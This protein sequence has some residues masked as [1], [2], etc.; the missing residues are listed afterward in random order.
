MCKL[1]ATE[2]S[3]PPRS[4]QTPRIGQAHGYEYI[5]GEL[6]GIGLRNRILGIKLAPLFMRLKSGLLEAYY[7]LFVE[8]TFD[9]GGTLAYA[10]RIL[11]IRQI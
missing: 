11:K 8:D 2:I 3:H 7:Y 5:I 4:L 6:N 9:F 10:L 1:Q